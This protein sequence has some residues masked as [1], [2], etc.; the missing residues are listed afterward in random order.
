MSDI[1]EEAARQLRSR[2]IQ[3]LLDSFASEA[4]ISPDFVA[5]C[6]HPYDCTCHKCLTWWASIGPDGDPDEPGA[7]GPFTK[8]DIEAYKTTEKGEADGPHRTV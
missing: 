1:Y 8:A 2:A 5:A 3:A 6:E 7:Y 4:G